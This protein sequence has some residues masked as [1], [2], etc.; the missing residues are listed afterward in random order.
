MQTPR[1]RSEFIYESAPFPECHAVT[2]CEVQGEILAAW[3]GGTREGKPDVGI[4]LSREIDGQWSPPIEIADGVE[5]PTLRYPAW[6]PVLFQPKDGPLYLFYKV[7]PR[8]ST[9]W[10]MVKTSADN[11]HTW[12]E[13]YRLPKGI[14]GAIKNKPVELADGTLLAPSSDESNGWRAH[15]ER[16]TDSGQTWV[17]HSVPAAIGQ[18]WGAIQPTIL[19]H[20]NGRLQALCRSRGG[21]KTLETWSKNGGISWSRLASL[22]LPNPNSGLDGVTLQDGRHLVVYNPVEAGPTAWGERTPLSVAIS[23]DGRSW[24][25]VLDLETDP[26]EYSYPAVIQAKDGTIHIAYTWN[27]QRLRHV[28]LSPQDI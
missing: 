19:C 6:N 28:T 10:G 2:L 16:S 14:L 1:I 24:N 25:R 23:A 21:G 22:D 11:G 8:P 3:F 17:R 9:W 4:W 15:F 18:K 7:G 12:S 13:P 26:G 5:S 27:R 20:P